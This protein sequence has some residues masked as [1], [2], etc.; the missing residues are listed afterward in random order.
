MSTIVSDWRSPRA[1][2]LLAVFLVVV[3]GVGAFI[4]ISTAPGEWYAALEKPPFN[5]PNAVFGPVWFTLYLVIAIAG[6]RTFLRAPNGPAMKLWYGQMILNWLWSPVW[7]TLHWLWPAFVV[8]FAIFLLILTF[9]AR[10][11]NEDRVSAGLFVP[12]AAW[13]GFA[14]LLN[15]SIA[16]LN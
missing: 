12:Y 6:W 3:I 14:S 15:L 4:G 7:F 11:W 16:I 9:I 2:T 8:I 13:V 1:L 10:S 5:P